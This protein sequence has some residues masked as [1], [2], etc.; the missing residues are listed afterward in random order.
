MAGP[1]CGLML[2]DLGAEVIKVEKYPNGDDARN[3]KSDKTAGAN[4]ALAGLP[5]SF[6]MLNR[7]KQSIALDIKHPKGREVLKR[8]VRQSDVL[9]E[10]FRP[11]TLD[12]LGLGY[13]ALSELNPALI[14]ASVSGYGLRGPLAEKGGFDLIAQAFAGI[15][16][17]TGEPGRPPVKPGVSTADINAGILAVVGIL[18]AYVHRLKTGKGQRVETSLMQAAMQQTYWL[19]AAYFATGISGQPLGTAHPVIAPY[20][21]FECADGSIALGGANETNWKRICELLGH[22]E[23][24]TDA[25]FDDGG[26]RLKNR[27]V[28]ETLMNPIFKQHSRAHWIAA[29]DAVGVPVGPVQSVGEALDHPQA[30]AVDMVIEADAPQGGRRMALGLPLQ[31]DGTNQPNRSAPPRVGQHTAQVLGRFGFEKEE[32]ATLLKDAAVFEAAAL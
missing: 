16:S 27:L 4:A 28:L 14:Y 2:A 5:P 11:G 32:I 15:I 17:V 7:G 18:A 23:W 21:C 9:T 29:F 10:N 26:K 24:L 6:M 1:T 8:M 3:Y 30:L 25:R 19:A 13:T 12:K 20:Q 22:P 31:L